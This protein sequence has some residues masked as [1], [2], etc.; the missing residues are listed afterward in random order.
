[1]R[2]CLLLLAAV[3]LGNIAVVM[4]LATLTD[5]DREKL[6]IVGNEDAKAIATRTTNIGEVIF[7]GMCRLPLVEN[8]LLVIVG[9]R[10]LCKAIFSV[11]RLKYFPILSASFKDDAGRLD[12]IFGVFKLLGSIFD[13]TCVFIFGTVGYILS[14]YYLDHVQ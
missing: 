2:V 5:A 6:K 13:D 8:M 9:I 14:V 1:M 10:M 11:L 3:V 4:E 7:S 12:N